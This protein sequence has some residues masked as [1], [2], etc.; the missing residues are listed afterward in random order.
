MPFWHARRSAGGDTIEFGLA[1]D[2]EI[3]DVDQAFLGG[4]FDRRRLHRQRELAADHLGIGVGEAE[5]RA[6]VVGLQNDHV[7][8]LP[9]RAAADRP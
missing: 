4:G 8:S 2:G 3:A 6:G 1:L 9:L 5:E 7:A